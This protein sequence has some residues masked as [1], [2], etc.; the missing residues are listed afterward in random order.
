MTRKADK[1]AESSLST[2]TAT[3]MSLGRRELYDEHGTGIY[4]LAE[5]LRLST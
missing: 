3:E 4:Q 1:V 2:A 5:Y